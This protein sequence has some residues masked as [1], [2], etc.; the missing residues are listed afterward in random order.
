MDIKNSKTLIALLLVT[1]IVVSLGYLLYGGMPTEKQEPVRV[2]STQ[3]VV[4]LVVIDKS[5]LNT[6][7]ETGEEVADNG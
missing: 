6:P 4:S 3:G 1:V 7:I 5:E 2:S